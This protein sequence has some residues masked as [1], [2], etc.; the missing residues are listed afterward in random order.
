MIAVTVKISVPNANVTATTPIV[1]AASPID[2]RLGSEA[3]TP[4]QPQHDVQPGRDAE[5]D[6]E[7]G[8]GLEHDHDRGG[9][10]AGAEDPRTIG[11]APR[12][13]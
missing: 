4:E 1:V 12:T 8:D 13:G 9:H 2:R 3:E 11:G 10:L 7:R 6:E 5:Q